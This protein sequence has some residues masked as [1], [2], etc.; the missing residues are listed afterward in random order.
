MSGCAAGLVAAGA[1][2]LGPPGPQ[3][4]TVGPRCCAPCR[5]LG[6]SRGREPPPCS[7]RCLPR[8]RGRD[9]ALKQMPKPFPVLEEKVGGGICAG[10][11]LGLGGTQGSASWRVLP[12]W[13]LAPA[14]SRDPRAPACLLS[15][16]QSRGQRHSARHP[17]CRQS[18]VSHP[19]PM[20]WTGA[21]PCGDSP[22]LGV[23]GGPGEEP[24]PVRPILPFPR[25]PGATALPG[26]V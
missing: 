3:S 2:S 20:L 5:H 22:G 18:W 10:G 15:R 9:A 6:L 8:R 19:F 4:G 26:P 23:L 17:S 13:S 12:G 7:R 21:M 11:S 14:R 24:D 16:R 1:A 25:R